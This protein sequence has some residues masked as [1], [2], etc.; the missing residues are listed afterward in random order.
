MFGAADGRHRDRMSAPIA[1]V[2]ESSVAGV[3][4]AHRLAQCL[5]FVANAC[6]I[7]M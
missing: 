7:P 1:E 4:G 6:E 3:D 5:E 2:Y